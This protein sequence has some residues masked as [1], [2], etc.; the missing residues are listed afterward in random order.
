V[1][2]VVVP[3]GSHLKIEAALTNDDVGFVHAE[4]DDEIK[5]PTFNYTA[6][7]CSLARC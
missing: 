1:L 6:V 7:G 4:P 2:A 5:G 3:Q